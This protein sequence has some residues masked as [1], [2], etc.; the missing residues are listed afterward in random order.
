LFISPL[1]MRV[2]SSHHLMRE[3]SFSPDLLLHRAARQQMLGA[4]D[5]GRLAQD[6]RAAMRH[7]QIHCRA[8]RRVGADAAE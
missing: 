5:L 3:M 7:Q 8:Q 6:G 4:I 1:L 2:Y